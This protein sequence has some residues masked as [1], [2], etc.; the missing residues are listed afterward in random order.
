MSKVVVIGGGPAGMFA[1]YFAAKNGHKVTLLEQNEKLGKKLYITGKGRCNIIWKIFLR[2]YVATRNFYI[3][4]FIHI[5][6][7]RW[8]SSLKTMDLEPRWSVVIEFSLYRT[9]H[10]M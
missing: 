2:T 6:M 9:I 10:Q 4:H 7:I 5:P 8:S 3:V 1:A